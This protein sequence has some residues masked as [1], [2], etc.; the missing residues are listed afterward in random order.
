MRQSTLL[1]AAA[2]L[3]VAG[4]AADVARQPAA[5]A[6]ATERTVATVDADVA[7]QLDTHYQRALK[8]GSRWA[9]VGR[10][11]QGTVYRPVDSTLT[12]EGANVHEAYI[13]VDGGR[14][15]GF[16]LPAERAFAPLSVKPAIRLAQ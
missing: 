12:I 10:L 15:V 5:L 11:P 7:I 16:Y 3:M 14:L 4:C 2:L 8:R 1:L 13:V 9:P 6:E